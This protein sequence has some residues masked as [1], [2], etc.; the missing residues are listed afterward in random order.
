MR[1]RCDTGIQYALLRDV[2]PQAL[3][4]QVEQQIRAAEDRNKV[5]LENAARR[6]I[7]AYVNSTINPK[8]VMSLAQLSLNFDKLGVSARLPSAASL[9]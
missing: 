9:S 1:V 4:R 5:F 2:D 7:D 6:D 8:P 3:K